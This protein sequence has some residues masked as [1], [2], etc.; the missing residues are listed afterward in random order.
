VTLIVSR[1]RCANEAAPPDVYGPIKRHVA[2]AFLIRTIH[3][4]SRH[5]Q[6]RAGG[7]LFAQLAIG[8]VERCDCGASAALP[9]NNT[10]IHSNA[11]Q[12]PYPEG[13]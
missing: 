5:F 2:A 6:T 13:V 11:G 4:A 3:F 9:V 10:F 1:A 7:S 8:F 12:T